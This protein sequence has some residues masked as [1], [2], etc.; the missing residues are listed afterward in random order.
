MRQVGEWLA[1]YQREPWGHEAFDMRNALLA[2]VIA[3]S[4]G[5]KDVKLEQFRLRA[6]DPQP[7]GKENPEALADKVRAFFQPLVRPLDGEA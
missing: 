3:R 1:H 6:P 7:A 5:T 4:V 2:L